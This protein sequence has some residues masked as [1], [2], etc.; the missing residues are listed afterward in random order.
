[1]GA[2]NMLLSWELL[3][4]VLVQNNIYLLNNQIQLN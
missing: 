1:M 2:I 3:T 4:V